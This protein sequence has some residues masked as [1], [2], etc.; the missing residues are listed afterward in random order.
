MNQKKEEPKPFGAK[1]DEPRE[2]KP[3][4]SKTELPSSLQSLESDLK[5]AIES[6]NSENISNLK[7][8]FVQQLDAEIKV[9]VETD[10]F[11]LAAALKKKLLEYPTKTSNETNIVETKQ[12]KKWNNR[13]R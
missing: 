2:P 4:G 5:K 6:E 10:D 3:F 1:K 13:R 8:K 9:A 12:P 7:K 11:E